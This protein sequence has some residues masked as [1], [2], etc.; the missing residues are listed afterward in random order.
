MDPADSSVPSIAE[1]YFLIELPSTIA[2][3]I[4]HVA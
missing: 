1:S 3:E 2:E 4:H